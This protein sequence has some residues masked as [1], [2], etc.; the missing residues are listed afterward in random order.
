MCGGNSGASAYLQDLHSAFPA[1]VPGACSLR[2]EEVGTLG[3]H[4][5]TWPCWSHCSPAGQH[6][7]CRKCLHSSNQLPRATRHR[8]ATHWSRFHRTTFCTTNEGLS[9]EDWGAVGALWGLKEFSRAEVPVSAIVYVPSTSV[10]SVGALSR[11]SGL[12]ARLLPHIPGH[13]SQAHFS[14]EQRGARRTNMH[15]C[16]YPA[17]PPGAALAGE[18]SALDAFATHWSPTSL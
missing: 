15:F 4:H 11:W 17:S 18:A 13:M 16:M 2:R 12:P 8:K 6:A 7:R 9:G 10:G 3:C 14:P 5:G 1:T